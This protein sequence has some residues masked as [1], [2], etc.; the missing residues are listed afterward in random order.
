MRLSEHILAALIAWTATSGAQVVINEINYDPVDVTKQTEFIELYNSGASAV[1]LSGWKLTE[2]VTFTFPAGTSIPA[3]GYKVVAQN[4]VDF[5]AKYGFAPLGPWVGVL[6]NRGDTVEIKNNAAVT[7]DSVPY[8]SGFPWPTSARGGGKS[9]ELIHFSLDNSLGGSWRSSNS[10]T[11]ATPGAQNNVFSATAPPQIRQVTHTPQQPTAG[12]PV[13]VTARVT[14]PQGIGTVTLRYQSVNPGS[15]IR[16]TD[17]AYSTSWTN[18]TML[19]DGLNND[20]L[21][22]DGIYTVTLPATL[23]INRR[24]VRYR[25][26]ATDSASASITVPYSDDE[27]PNF[28][29]FVYNGVPAWNGAV[30]PGGAGSRAV[31]QAYPATLL[32]SLQT[33]QLI[34]SSADLDNSLYNSDFNGALFYGTIVYDGKVYDHIRY[35]NRG[36]GSTYVSGKNKLALFFNRARNIRVKDNWGN[37]Y[38]EDWNSIPINACAAPWSPVIRGSAGV[39]EALSY[40]LYT[41][42]G[43]Y[44]LNTH[45]MHW[46]IIRNASE[47]GATQYDSDFFGLYLGLEPTEGNFLDERALPDGNIYAVE[48]G[49]GDKKHQ[50]AT[51]PTSNSDWDNFRNGANQGGQTEQWYRDN[52]DLNALYT[53]HAI[54]RFCGNVDVRGGDNFRY[55]HRSSDNRW[56]IMPYDMD[57]MMIPAHH[58]GTNVDGLTFAGVPD[59]IRAITRHPNLAKEY[60]N[61][62]REI[63]DLLGSDASVSGGQVGQLVDEYA[64]I[65]NPTG[66]ALTWADADEAMWCNHPRTTGGHFNNFY[67]ASFN[68]SRGNL[69]GTPGTSWTRTLPDPDGNG[70]SDFEGLMQ[71]FTRF[72]TNTW[73]GGTWARSNGNP[74]GYGWKYLEWESLYGGFGDVYS[75][76]SSADL[77]FP[78]TPTITY[79]GPVGYPANALDFTSSNFSASSGGGTTFA[80]MQWRIGEIYAPGIPGYVAGE[81]RKYEIENVWTSAELPTFS[82]TIRVPIDQA[83]PGST[84]RAR[85]RHKDA[86]GRWSHWSAPI[87]FV[88]GTPDITVY[89]QSIVVSEVNYNPAPVS[90]SEFTAGYSSDDFEWIE[91]KNVSAMPLNCTGLRFTK[92]VDFDFPAGYTIPAGGFALIVRN[93]AAFQLRWGNSFNAIIAGTFPTDNLSNNTEQ[94]KLSYGA[95]TG[96]VDF[97]YTDM[98]PWPAAADGTGKTLTLRNP[99]S[100]PNPALPAN[101]WRG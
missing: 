95:G 65:I 101:S 88:A 15:Y 67:R 7:Q 87:Q 33:W 85:V 55:Y 83:K 37:Y 30:Q 100:L 25:I 4:V 21:A 86:N 36:I 10:G 82:A 27:Q 64:Q 31:V 78:N 81:K 41:L 98:A 72:T 49:G 2:A 90:P 63:L 12:V 89:Q 14:D 35:H 74:N 62:A 5:Q 26:V 58:W 42:A 47:T 76:P 32:N 16:R 40:R 60:R 9:A 50:G 97:T 51:Q 53:F 73:S 1:D 94:L 68:D 59:Q 8:E 19:D 13:V 93:Q 6:S 20:A 75:E 52:I 56:V 43:A 79:N 28:A 92:G 23:Q 71:F 77:A 3:G 99:A 39:E 96:V 22:G 17:S 84:Y 70:F 29:Y 57:M 54:N 69:N 45:F 38:K 61:R 91:V 11:G 18:V 46:R 24:L 34:T 66:L 48:G 80:A 44:S